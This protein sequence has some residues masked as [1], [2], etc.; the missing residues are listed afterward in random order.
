M[1]TQTDLLVVPGEIKLSIQ[2]DP[3][4]QTHSMVPLSW[5]LSP[6]LAERMRQQGVD[7]AYML[8]VVS[9]GGVEIT[10]DVVPLMDLMTYV[11][12]RR[13]GQNE[14][15][16]TVVYG[17]E[18]KKKLRKKEDGGQYQCQVLEE[19]DPMLDSHRNVEGW[20]D[21]AELAKEFER[22]EAEL[23]AESEAR[24]EVL[25]SLNF[26]SMRRLPEEGTLRVE[27]PK[28]MFAKE[29]SKFRQWWVNQ[30]PWERRP[31]DQC[32]FRKRTI[33]SIPLVPVWLAVKG[34]LALG[35][36]LVSFAY[37]LFLV[38]MGSRELDFRPFRHP[39]NCAPWEVEGV[40][41]TSMWYMREDGSPTSAFAFFVNPATITV[42]VSALAILKAFGVLDD[43][44]AFTGEYIVPI[45]GGIVGAVL[46]VIGT[47]VVTNRLFG[48]RIEAW[49]ERRK[50]KQEAEA[51]AAHAEYLEELDM[52]ACGDKP[53][54]TTLK[55]LPP[56][57]RTL[58]LRFLNIKSKVCKTYAN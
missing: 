26:S 3:E 20:L 18:V 25:L 1:P 33:V 23:M 53:Q 7:N 44:V 42:L 28:E 40:N 57:R 52:L 49:W 41:N 12:F 34:A 2:Q 10:R 47:Y 31:H 19:R 45:L 48:D 11:Q 29:P 6:D 15:H 51:K 17:S 55:D 8:I 32:H 14:I 36:E 54:P 39:F 35:L 38:V 50:A 58:R 21:F 27:V 37:L 24:Q 46:L 22:D 9:N 30:L 43:V 4:G 16:A 56:E 13:P 5:C